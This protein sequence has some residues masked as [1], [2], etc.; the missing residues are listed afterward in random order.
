MIITET[1]SDRQLEII[2][3]AGKILTK[4]G[5]SGLTIKNLA[6]E[7]KFSESA[8]YRHFT[9][10]EEIII[11]LLEYLAQ[12]MDERYA[13]AISFEQSPEEKFIMLFQNQFSFFNRNPHFVVAVF[14]DGLMEESQRINGTILKIM[15]IKMKHLMP[16]ILEGQQKNV[17]T[18]SL[19][20]DE[21]MHIVMGAFRLE[22]YKWRVANFQ[23][24]IIQSGDNMIHAVL[25]LIK[26]K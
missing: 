13:N 2:G 8:I 14:S 16:I 4:S 19:K 15:S 7:M 6:K 25:T 26:C 22:M 11:A 20:T 10:K 21:L 9:S 3:A 23:F 17:F 12:S 1:I 18:N 5:I 24:D